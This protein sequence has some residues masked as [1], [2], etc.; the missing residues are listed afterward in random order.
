MCIY[1]KAQMNTM[2][3]DKFDLSA[4][5]GMLADIVE[6]LKNPDADLP[7]I[8]SFQIKGDLSKQGSKSDSKYVK[9]GPAYYNPDH[10]DLSPNELEQKQI[11][12]AIRM[13]E[14]DISQL[15]KDPTNLKKQE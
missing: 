4:H 15:E 11:E 3:E 1:V 2:I 10:I 9:V 8:D 14:E 13:Q 5:E 12:A 7:K 6:T